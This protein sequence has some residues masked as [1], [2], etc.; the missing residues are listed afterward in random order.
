MLI[1]SLLCFVTFSIAYNTTDWVFPAEDS[2]YTFYTGDTVIP[3]WTSTYLTATDNVAPGIALL[4][5]S[6]GLH[7]WSAFVSANGTEA[8]SLT[9]LDLHGRALPMACHFE[10]GLAT[11]NGTSL[12]YFLDSTA[13]NASADFTII[14]AA[15]N[16]KPQIWSATTPLDSP[17]VSASITELSSMIS[18]LPSKTVSANAIGSAGAPPSFSATSPIRTPT[19]ASETSK[20]TSLSP[21]SKAGIALGVVLGVGLLAGTLATGFII[22]KRRRLLVA[23]PPTVESGRS[24]PSPSGAEKPSHDISISSSPLN[25]SVRHEAADTERPLELDSVMRNELARRPR[26]SLIYG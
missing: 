22:G 10:L 5:G 2:D 14:D 6:T 17:P 19:A 3:F 25:D 1:A 23:N 18:S 11:A 7:T 16:S 4:C 8:C 13:T 24:M 20:G 12:P 15:A 9:D 26:L 21:G